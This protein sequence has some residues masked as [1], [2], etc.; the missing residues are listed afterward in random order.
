MKPRGSVQLEA[1]VSPAVRDRVARIKQRTGRTYAEILTMALDAVPDEHFD[2]V[3]GPDQQASLPMDDHRGFLTL[4]V[5][6][7]EHRGPVYEL[8]IGQVWVGRVHRALSGNGFE[9]FTCNVAGT[10]ECS[11]QR[12]PMPLEQAK[13]E[14]ERHVR[15]QFGETGGHDGR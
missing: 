4:P 3:A 1:W 2:R 8:H 9:W 5:K 15:A 7:L 13:A 14:C 10:V 11:Y 6:W 12:P